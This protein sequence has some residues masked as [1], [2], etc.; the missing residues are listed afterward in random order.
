MNLLRNPDLKLLLVYLLLVVCQL[1]RIL[2]DPV[3]FTATDSFY[4]LEAA[5]NL[6]LGNGPVTPAFPNA[7]VPDTSQIVY[8]TAFP[9]GYPLGIAAV[10]WATGVSVFWASKV[11]NLLALGGA[12][13]VLRKFCRANAWLLALAF[14]TF[15]QLEVFA[16][17][18]SEGLFT[19]LLLLFGYLLYQLV[20]GRAGA[21][22]AL[23][24]GVTG[25]L[26]F[27]VKYIGVFGLGL[28]VLAALYCWRNN[29]K[30]QARW[31]VLAT[32]GIGVFIALYLGLNYY[33][34]GLTWGGDRIFNS[35]KSVG[36]FVS[37]IS[38]G[39]FN[40]LNLMRHYYFRG[41]FD[42]LFFV[43][44][45]VQVMWLGLIYWRLI[46]HKISL[47]VQATDELPKF[48]WLVAGVYFASLIGLRLLSPFDAF[49]YRL[50]APASLFFYL[51]I[52]ALLASP[53]RTQKS[54]KLKVHLALFLLFCLLFQLPKAWLL[55]FI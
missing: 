45:A 50:M 10:S 44:L 33:L 9:I 40:E 21:L 47:R 30:A 29:R 35:G 51:G 26:L 1:L 22:F 8:L 55:S 6:V 20:R 25:C 15:T 42:P 4:Y 46:R 32:F 37:A 53:E 14:G 38:R 39:V 27:L 34:T 7:E 48:F 54:P 16:Y 52:L 36:H 24:A 3:G 41:R 28:L 5:R 11:V 31:L 12:L 18:W 17:T 19:F 2:G 23:F 43:L 13:L 49:Y